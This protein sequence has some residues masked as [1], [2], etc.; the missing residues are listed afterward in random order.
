[1]SIISDALKKAQDRRTG[2]IPRSESTGSHGP[3]AGHSPARKS[4]VIGILALL[5][6][7][8]LAF[9]VLARRGMQATVA[10]GPGTDKDA[11][12]PLSHSVKEAVSPVRT[13]AET[14]AAR[15]PKIIGTPASSEEPKPAKMPAPELNGIMYSPTKPQAVVNGEMVSEGETA[16]GWTVEKIFPD[17]VLLSSGE[18]ETELKLR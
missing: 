4:I 6:I 12:S 1:M 7:S 9:G 3:A 2:T 5:V 11:A 14:L 18:E 13:A 16:G 15:L 10:A 8:G 17:R